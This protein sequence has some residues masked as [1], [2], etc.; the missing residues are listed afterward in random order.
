MSAAIRAARDSHGISPLSAAQESSVAELE[1]PAP[2]RVSRRV[3]ETTTLSILV[4][5]SVSHMLNDM[6]Q[7]LAPALYPVFRDQLGLTFF[8]TGLI[9]F[10]FQITASLLQPLIGLYTDRRPQPYS[11]PVAML[12]TL[13]GLTLLAFGRSY[14][15]LLV[16][17]ALIGVGSAIF[18]PESSRV[19]RAAS[20]GRHGFA[21]SL[22]QVGG[23]FGQ[24]LGPLMAAFI[25]VPFG[26]TSVV[27]FSALALLGIVILTRV[28][29]WYAAHRAAPKAASAVAPHGLPR[30]LVGR[31]IAILVVLVS[32]KMFYL[33]SLSSYYTFYLI[34]TFHTSVQE[35]Q[36][37]L[38]IF[39]SA[40]AA[41]TFVGGPIG[42]RFG[43]KFVIWVSIV[44]VL[45]F[46]IALSHLN[47][48]WTAVDSVAIGLILAS[49]FSAII[50]FAQELV[51]GN[52]GAIAGLFFGL[53]FGLG[54]IGAAVL[55]EVA[56]LT[57]L[58]FVYQVC[59]FLPAI[60][61]LT[62]FLPN[63]RSRRL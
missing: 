34:Q 9:T 4:A 10:T 33:S 23:N 30:G 20:G 36:I 5:I 13:L 57:S 38:F 29:Q 42:D 12:F 32:S 31:S 15:F 17:V 16:S 54:G 39:L 49:A 8:E 3:A 28:S 60:G 1:A 55:G 62:Y 35:S 48:F 7:S 53:A 56:D 26:Q 47:L 59:G 58:T 46:T 6:M 11:L 22:F 24:S 51:P 43:R 25:V 41:G 27:W 45:P 44:G 52:V 2:G 19:A 18:H 40:V 21:Q 63:L 37:Y 50:V 61:L 14:T